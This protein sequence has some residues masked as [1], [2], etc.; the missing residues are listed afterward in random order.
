MMKETLCMPIALRTSRTEDVYSPFIANCA[1]NVYLSCTTVILNIVSI[2][3]IRK[4]SSLPKTLKTLLLS[5]A[6]SDLGV[7]LLV[8]PLYVSILVRWLQKDTSVCFMFTTVFRPI[9]TT[10]SLA[11]FFGV[12]ALSADRFLAIRLHL[13]YQELVTHKLVN[14]TVIL[15]WMLSVFISLLTLF[16]KHP[17]FTPIAVS[18]VLGFCF[19]STTYFYYQIYLAVQR[20][21]RQIQAL[22]LQVR[23]NRER[24]LNLAWLRKSAIGTLYMYLVLLICFLPQY[25]SLL[26]LLF[27]GPNQAAVDISL[28]Y[29]WTLLFLNSSLNPLIYC[30]KMRSIRRYIMN[31]LYN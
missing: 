30:W 16:L 21:K 20:H 17:L 29:T 25:C 11:S 1:F 27:S 15:T 5:L 4:A 18:V 10:F 19:I 28:L 6:V 14:V 2:H 23:P 8:Q 26:S 31:I 24:A 7:G 3:A 13:R 12:T 9:M 22:Q